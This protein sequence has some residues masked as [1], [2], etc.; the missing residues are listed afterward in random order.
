[1]WTSNNRSK[2]NSNPLSRKAPARKNNYLIS[3]SNHLF[4]KAKVAVR[5]H[6]YLISNP[7]QFCPLFIT[8]VRQKRPRLKVPLF[9][10][11]ICGYSTPQGTS[12]KV[13]SLQVSSS[14]SARIELGSPFAS[15]QV[16][17]ANRLIHRSARQQLAVR[18]DIDAGDQ[19]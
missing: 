8:F 15:V 1:M 12:R 7:Y 6:D 3:K 19:S 14:L 9:C 17:Y 2:W 11:S 18:R 4:G 5:K 10:D 16:P 13:S